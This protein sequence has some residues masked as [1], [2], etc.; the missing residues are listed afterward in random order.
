MRLKRAVTKCASCLAHRPKAGGAETK[1][2]CQIESD[3][4]G[5]EGRR[6]PLANQ[7]LI[8]TRQ[9]SP[10]ATHEIR[11]FGN[12]NGLINYLK[13]QVTAV[14]KSASIL[15]PPIHSDGPPEWIAMVIKKI[16]TACV[17]T[18]FKSAHGNIAMMFAL[19]LIPLMVGAGVGLD[20]ARAMLVRQQML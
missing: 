18:F 12:L 17:R 20:F 11:S 1:P 6:A 13:D 7:R 4:A 9:L 10:N 15:S 19:S 2:A 14:N 16:S 3:G 5:S 8:A